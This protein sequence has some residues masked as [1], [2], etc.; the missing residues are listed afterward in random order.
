MILI[1]IGIEVDKNAIIEYLN[2]KQAKFCIL[3]R[4]TLS[5]KNALSFTKVQNKFDIH[6]RIPAINA[7]HTVFSY[8][9]IRN[10]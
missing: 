5:Q 7:K 1:Q 4:L 3:P 8:P 9:Q 6:I 10:L 2:R